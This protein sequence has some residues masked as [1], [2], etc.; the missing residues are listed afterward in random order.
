[1]AAQPYYLTTPIYYVNDVPH[2]GHAYTTLAC[3]ALARFQRLDGREVFFLTGTDEHG[4]KVEKAARDLGIEP[5]QLADRNSQRFRD[6]A[7]DMGYSNDDFIRTTEDRHI[8]AVQHLWREL[9]A[10]EE[11]YLGTYAGWYS[12]RDEAFFA[13]SELIKG[14]NGKLIAPTGTGAEVEWVEEPSYF[15]RLSAWQDRLLAFYDAH[16]DFIAPETRRNEVVSFVKGG[17]QDLSV[18]RTSF[19]WGVPVPDDPAHVMYVWI[20]ALT[21]YLTAVGYPDTKKITFTKFWP[22]DLHMVGKDI[23]RFH[24]VYWPAFLMAADIAPPK[25][26]FAHGWWTNEGRKISKSLGNVIDPYDLVAKYGRDQVRYFL[27]RE[28]PFGNDGDFSHTAMINR[29]N[30]DLANDFGNLAQRVLSMINKN[31]G[32]AVPAPGPLSDADTA[33][34]D[35]ARGLLDVLREHFTAQQFHHAL[36]TLWAQIQAANRYVDTEAPWKLRK[37]DPARMNTVLWVLAEAIRHYAIL[38]QPVT[39]DAAGRILD[40]LAVAPEA[41]TFAVLGEVGALEPGTALPKP[42]GVFPRLEAEAAS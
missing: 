3:D 15:F 39:P 31:C 14:P 4:Q 1:M 11:I 38:A 41:R 33:L 16:P 35:G 42:A 2:I 34:L 18:S 29:A 7:R 32:A 30:S 9:V 28:V 26:V 40:Q 6:L 12:V 19:S 22:T 8:R 5:Q 25:R 21:N 37:D 13:E 20:D 17:L 24:A 23:L 36:T 27:L 10:R